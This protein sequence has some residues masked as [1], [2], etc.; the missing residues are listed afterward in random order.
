[1]SF[2]YPAKPWYEGQTVTHSLSDTIVMRG[3]YVEKKNLW[4]F[5]RVNTEGGVDADG[6]IFTPNVLSVNV[7][8]QESD[9]EPFADPD[10]ISNQQDINWYLFDQSK[11]SS[12][13]IGEEPPPEDE[14]F[15]FWYD[16]SRLE[17]LIYYN[18]Q[19]FPVSV[20]PSQIEDLR[21]VLERELGEVIKEVTRV[22]T[23]AGKAIA[24]LSNSMDL[25]KVLTNG[26]VADQGI[27]LRSPNA[28]ES[29][30]DAIILAP[31]LSR[32]T[33]A[34]EEKENF[35]PTFQL[36]EKGDKQDE[37]R[38][39]EFELD[40]GRL[41]INM[42]EQQDEVHFRF[43]DEEELIL[44]HRSNP[45]GASELMG[46]LK[47]DP[48]QSGNEV[49]TYEQLEEVA[50]VVG[51]IQDNKEKGSWKVESPEVSHDMDDEPTVPEVGDFY[52]EFYSDRSEELNE[53]REAYFE[54]AGEANGDLVN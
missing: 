10:T 14:V 53:C 27:I 44:R 16:T 23:E 34:A 13:W 24:D 3:T 43:R 48:G 50:G 46:R 11:A 36:I 49:V 6:N 4:V 38:T 40:E 42:T 19:W 51:E 9:I 41:D 33:L 22:E 20:P 29:D 8:P 21:V 35:L 31:T 45:A 15:G 28:L 52:M 1:M 39:A 32:I 2:P 5:T 54:C 26:A 17:L 7:R 18:D 12:I 37:T 47:V 25:E 30:A